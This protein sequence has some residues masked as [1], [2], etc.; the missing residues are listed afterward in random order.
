[1]KWEISGRVCSL[2]LF[3]K[4][5]IYCWDLLLND[6]KKRNDCFKPDLLVCVLVELF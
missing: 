6:A 2:A 4:V 3:Q 5:L 1:M